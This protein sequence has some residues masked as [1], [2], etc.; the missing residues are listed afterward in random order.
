LDFFIVNVAIPSTQED[1]HAG[2]AAI[3]WVVAGFGLAV[4]A[5]LITGGRLGDLYG[6]RRIFTAGLALFTPAS[7]ACGL[8]GSP[9][10]VVAA[11]V[12]QGA[13][14]ALLMPQVLGIINIAF[15]GRQRVRA[16]TAY[17]L[18]LGFA[19]VFGQLI[20]GALIQVDVAGLGWRGIFWINVPIGAVAL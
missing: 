2:S 11:R 5:G 1:L 16:F 7:A 17:G 6:R 4:A 12:T 13:A 3:Q 20:G 14:A 18:A 8:A 10:T 15:T 9:A 19:A